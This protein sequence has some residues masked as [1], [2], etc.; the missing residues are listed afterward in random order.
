MSKGGTEVEIL[1][2][3]EKLRTPFLDS[4]FSII[5]RFGE[6]TLFIIVGILFLWCINKKNGY[7]LFFVGFSG[8][9]INQFL[10]FCFR[11][12]RPWVRDPNLT[13]VDNYAME[14]AFLY[15]KLTTLNLCNLTTIKSGGL[16]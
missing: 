5:T 2:M 10:K 1:R 15:T 11:V 13:V 12:P 3:L 7:Y 14:R 16:Y 8:L 6:E 4:F 9:L